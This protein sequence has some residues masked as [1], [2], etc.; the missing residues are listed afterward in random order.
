M[1]AGDLNGD[2]RAEII[3][4][5]G[6]GMSATVHVYDGVSRRLVNSFLPFGATFKGGVFVAAGDVNGDGVRDV[7]TSADRGWL[8]YVS[9][10]EGASVYDGGAVTQLARFRAFSNQNRTG[11]RVGVAP[12]EGS[13]IGDVD[14]VKLLL[15]TGPQGGADSRKVRQAIFNGLTPTVI[16]RLFENAK[17]KNAYVFDGI[18][19]D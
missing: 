12:V 15:G 10:F 19:V 2:G 11:V 6:P 17:V 16:D 1:A 14:K 9:V 18:F 5:S 13:S 3:T 8:P 4:G 7:I